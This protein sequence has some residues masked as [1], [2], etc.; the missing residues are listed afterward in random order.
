MRLGIISN[1]MGNPFALQSVVD[2]LKS[3]QADYIISAGNFIGL[4]PG[5]LEVIEIA[6]RENIK[7]VR[8][9]W[10]RYFEG[11]ENY[12][13]VSPGKEELVK[14]AKNIYC[15]FGIETIANDEWLFDGI[16][17]GSKVHF[18]WWLPFLGDESVISEIIAQMGSIKQIIGGV[19]FSLPKIQCES[20][21]E[22]PLYF[23]PYSI[24]FLENK[25]IYPGSVGANRSACEKA[26]F[27]FVDK[28][29]F[30]FHEIN[31]PIEKAISLVKNFGEPARTILNWFQ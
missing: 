27:A 9:K 25:I 7:L 5:N 28:D 21:V 18:S 22:I 11:L 4:I 1:V 10:E 3:L 12:V 16:R 2:S 14:H 24:S 23:T 8:G 19:P 15:K 29:Q 6:Q 13:G 17:I 31:Y 20:S 30:I 26:R